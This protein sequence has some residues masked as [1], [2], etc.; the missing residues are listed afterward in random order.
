MMEQLYENG[1]AA[2]LKLVDARTALIATSGSFESIKQIGRVVV[3]GSE[4]SPVYLQEVA[5]IDFAYADKSYFTRINGVNSV[6]VTAKQKRGQN[7]NRLMKQVR[8]EVEQYSAQ[9]PPDVKTVWIYDQSEVVS[10]RLKS[11]FM[12]LTQGIVLVGLVILLALG[13]RPAVVV[14]MA[15][16]FSFI[17][18]MGWISATGYAIH[19][20]TIAALIISLGLL[21][22][23]GI[24]VTENINTHL[25]RGYERLQA[26]LRGTS[27]VGWAVVAS[28]VTTILAFLPIALMQD[29]SGDFI[30]SMPVS[31]MYILTASLLIALTVSPLAASRVLKP[32]TLIEQPV[33]TQQLR[34]FVNYNVPQKLD[35][36]LRWYYI[37]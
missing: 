31:V 24:V 33:F 15:V 21:V 20:M 6:L 29:A 16:P 19:Q 28:T 26:A 30:R 13:F 23:N 4:I 27:Q 18:A 37:T 25:L 17:I 12:N 35:S 1:I 2:Q 10:E 14:L 22:D 8:E 3:G 34:R 32:T 36:D 5:D 11:F 7:V 9:L